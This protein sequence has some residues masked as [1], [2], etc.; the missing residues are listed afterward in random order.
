MIKTGDHVTI[1]YKGRRYAADVQLASTNEASLFLT[2]EAIIDGHVGMMP[3]LKGNDGVYR[4][5][6]TNCEIEILP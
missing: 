1:V 6:V 2:F 4:S 3:V 5:I